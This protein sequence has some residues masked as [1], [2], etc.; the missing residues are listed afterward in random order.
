LIKKVPYL[1]LFA[2][3]TENWNRPKT[4]I[5][6]LMNLFDKALTKKLIE[7][8]NKKDICFR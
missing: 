6:F 2:F 5:K 7:R 3:S 1:S 4:E 8:L